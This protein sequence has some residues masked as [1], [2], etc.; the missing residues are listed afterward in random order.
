MSKKYKK[1]YKYLDYVE[2]LLVLASAVTGRASIS[3]FDSLVSVPVD[4]TSSA[5]ELNLCYYCRN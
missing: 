5:I 3:A 1:T 2:H 4:I